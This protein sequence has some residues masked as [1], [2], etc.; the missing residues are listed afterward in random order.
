M[1][2]NNIDEKEQA[3]LERDFEELYKETP[4]TKDTQCGY[5]IF[6]QNFLQP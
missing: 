5:W 2:V 6:R 3:L 4:L 1:D